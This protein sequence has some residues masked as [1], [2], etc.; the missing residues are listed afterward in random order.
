MTQSTRIPNRLVKKSRLNS[1]SMRTIPWTDFV[2][3]EAF[4]KA[5]QKIAIFLLIG[6]S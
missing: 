5:N 4:M 6:Y 2:G 1:C 3:E